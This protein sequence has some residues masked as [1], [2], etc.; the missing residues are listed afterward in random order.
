MICC[1]LIYAC[2]KCTRRR[3]WGCVHL[4]LSVG[5]VDS[6]MATLLCEEC[7]EATVHRFAQRQILTQQDAA[8]LRKQPKSAITARRCLLA[9]ET[10]GQ[11]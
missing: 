3:S 10:G 11:P 9:G 2:T 4:S 1:L 6:P 5:A 8:A 7:G